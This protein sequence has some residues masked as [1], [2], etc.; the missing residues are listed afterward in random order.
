MAND[1]IKCPLI[2]DMIEIGDCVVCS[3]V[4]ER[5]F[6]EEC[7]SERFRKKEN[8]REICGSCKYHDM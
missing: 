4:S 2:D 1:E 7:I 6:K 8:W 5:M 3:D